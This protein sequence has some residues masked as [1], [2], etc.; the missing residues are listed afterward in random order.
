MKIVNI[1]GGLGNQ[2]FQYAF[3]LALKYNFC[4]G[5]DI[6]ID[7]HHFKG[8]SL[9]QG[10]ELSK[11]FKNIELPLANWK[12]IQKVSYYIPNYKISRL[13]RKFLPNRKTEYQEDGT[14]K[15]YPEAISRKG[16]TYYEG[17][18]QAT[19]YINGVKDHI[20]HAFQFGR[21]TGENKSLADKMLGENSVSIHVRRGDYLKDPLYCGTCSENYYKKAIDYVLSKVNAPVFYIFSND[22][23]WCKNHILPLLKNSEVNIVTHNIGK[24]SYWD[25]F[26]MSISSSLIISNSSF[27]WWAAYLNGR[28]GLTIAP[29]KWIN[30]NMDVELYEDSWIKM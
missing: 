11:V 19:R 2:M 24:D 1:I 25:M 27:S 13:A 26:L 20:F 5:E 7:I 18:W 23:G 15:F 10:Y 17:Y 21:P 14:Y 28:D 3:A 29:E 22:I 9:H 16:D 8:Y 4:K 12:Q 6:Y 30:W